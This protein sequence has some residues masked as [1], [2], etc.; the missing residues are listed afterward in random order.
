MKDYK[1]G[2]LAPKRV[3]NTSD[4]NKKEL[5]VI[6]KPEYHPYTNFTLGIKLGVA[7]IPI[8]NRYIAEEV[9]Y[10]VDDMLDAVV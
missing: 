2:Y 3:N 7:S 6:V 10:W 8:T 1:N 4:N 5:R 9:A